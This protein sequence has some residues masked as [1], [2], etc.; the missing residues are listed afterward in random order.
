MD[1]VLERICSKKREEVQEA[2]S[3]L[4]LKDLEALTRRDSPPRGFAEALKKKLQENK[5]GLIAE[6]KKAS[7]SAG[8]IRADFNPAALAQAYED[9]G[10]ACLSVLT[11]RHW[12]QGKPEY[13][14][15]AREAGSLPVLRKDFMV[16]PWQ[17]AE[18]WAMGADCILLILAA[19]TDEEAKEMALASAHYGMDALA[20]VHNEEE[21]RRALTLP[22]AMIGINNR[23]LK[24]LKVDLNTSEMLAKQVPSSYLIISESGIK[25]PKDIARMRSHDIHCFLVGESLMREPD[26]RIATRHLLAPL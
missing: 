13:L 16:D 20:E 6:I 3:K 24:T 19:L 22:V 17:V 4:S 10:A 14:K 18:S 25:H 12:F 7:P 8:V 2:K 1:N 5:V 23:D 26:V 15:A 21:L 9:A 11:E